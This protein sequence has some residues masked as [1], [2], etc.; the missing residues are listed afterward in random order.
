MR[1]FKKLCFVVGMVSLG[2]LMLFPIIMIGA[3]GVR[4][5]AD[6]FYR[7]CRLFLILLPVALVSL[8]IYFSD[9]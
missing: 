9:L 7:A 3:L 6:Y 5:V 1:T 2:I 4:D 8:T